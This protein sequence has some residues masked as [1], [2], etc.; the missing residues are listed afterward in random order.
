MKITIL[1]EGQL[2]ESIVDEVPGLVANA[3]MN[4]LAFYLLFNDVLIFIDEK[5]TVDSVL[6][7]YYKKLK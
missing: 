7:T 2:G 4:H 3:R 6:E 1:Y 5:S